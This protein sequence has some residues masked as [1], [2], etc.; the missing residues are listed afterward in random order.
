MWHQ[1]T[2]RARRA[3]FFAQEEAA[4]LGEFRVGPE[5]LLLGLLRE[6]DS[7]SSRVLDRLGVPLMRVCK[8]V[9]AQIPP[10]QGRGDQNMEL[11]PRGKRS[12]ELAHEEARQMNNNYIGMEH[13]LLGIVR[14]GE[15]PAGKVLAELGADLARVRATVL[16]MQ[17]EEGLSAQ[18]PSSLEL[19]PAAPPAA[20][21][22]PPAA[23]SP[24]LEDLEQVV[25]HAGGVAMP[26]GQ[27]A[28]EPEDLLLR[29]LSLPCVAVEL[30][31][32][33]GVK[34]L[35][36][37]Q[38]LLRRIPERGQPSGRKVLTAR[39][40]RVLALAFE[41]FA[42]SP[43]PYLGSDYLLLGL[44]REGEEARSPVAATLLE[45]GVTLGLLRRAVEQFPEVVPGW[46]PATL[47]ERTLAAYQRPGFSLMRLGA[48]R[49]EEAEAIL[50]GAQREARQAAAPAV[51]PAH[52]LLGMLV[53]RPCRASRLLASLGV[54]LNRLQAALD[55][56]TESA[57]TASSSETAC[58]EL[59]LATQ[60][61]QVLLDALTLA[62]VR[63]D[64]CLDSRHLLLSLL[65]PAGGTASHLL[66]ERGVTYGRVHQA[67]E[68]A[69]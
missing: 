60:T 3:V 19:A 13:L 48:I 32:D 63:G 56:I 44:L 50:Q 43:R 37:E 7:I 58:P 68:A 29:I 1:F 25:T 8:E 21:S 57:R 66:R 34:R 17:S 52:L 39:T 14:E 15:G 35:A 38:S 22:A 46:K 11:S 18:S 6:P 53:G 55:R 20:A 2:E 9:E 41:E 51:A 5:H 36:L 31:S 64:D 67:M 27:V 45:A 23:A 16:Q 10:G 54:D 42:A 65:S 40:R 62:L 4:R 61:R 12:I 59:P 28:V 30:L 49:R 47:L 26:D 69:L 24:M 33:L